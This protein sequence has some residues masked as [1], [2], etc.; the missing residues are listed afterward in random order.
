M[1]GLVT[2][3]GHKF[4]HIQ[5]IKSSTQSGTGYH[6]VT[7]A[8]FIMNSSLLITATNNG[9]VRF[10]QLTCV[11]NPSRVLGKGPL[12]NLSLRYDL[13]SIHNGGIELLMNIGDILLT[14]GGNDGKIIGWDISKGI[15]LGR[16]C[17]HLGSDIEERGVAVANIR[18]C[19]VDLLISG[20]DG[21]MVSLCRDGKLRQLKFK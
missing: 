9:D 2:R 16:L 4:R 17:C 19:V 20:K 14:S 21:S 7:R 6:L 12:P 10:W 15:K 5:T 18:S 8:M 13:N 1:L 3:P 11:G